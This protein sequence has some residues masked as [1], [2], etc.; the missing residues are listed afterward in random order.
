MI[1]LLGLDMTLRNTGWCI[2]EQRQGM[3]YPLIAGVVRT[4]N[5]QKK[6][7]T[8][9]ME[10]NMRACTEVW[11]KLQEIVDDYQPIG[12][13]C[14]RLEGTQNSKAARTFGLAEGAL[15][16]IVKQNEL[17]IFTVGAKDCKKDLT[18]DKSASKVKIVRAIEKLYPEFCTKYFPKGDAIMGDHGTYAAVTE[19]IADAMSVVRFG[20]KQPN[21]AG[22][23]KL[24]ARS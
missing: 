14:E 1:T 17:P 6:R 9:A 22:L 3:W 20:I 2:H 4:K 5:E 23:L 16:A 21:I 15:A 10:E 13:I 8:Y 12:A 18:G 19:H 7:R 24:A 11:D